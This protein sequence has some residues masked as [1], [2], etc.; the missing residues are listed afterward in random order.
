MTPGTLVVLAIV[1]GMVF[2][3][4]R[5][6]VRTHRKGGLVSC[7]GCDGKACG[8]C[9]HQAQQTADAIERLGKDS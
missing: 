3:S 2:L 7:P 4:I 9:Q 5:S 1:L 6:M 8:A